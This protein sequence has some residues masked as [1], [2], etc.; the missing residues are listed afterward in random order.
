MTFD[1]QTAMHLQGGAD[2]HAAFGLRNEALDPRSS[3]V[4]LSG[5]AIEPS[6]GVFA[7]GTIPS[8]PHASSSSDGVTSTFYAHSTAPRINTDVL[9]CEALRKQ[10]PSLSLTVSLTYNCPLMTYA[11]AGFATAVPLTDDSSPLGN[12]L[13]WRLWAPPARRTGGAQ[14]RLADLVQYGKYLYKYRQSPGMKENEFIIY[15]VSGRDGT[16]PFG[17]Q[18]N[19]YI[20]SSASEKP[21]VDAL[22]KASA[23]WM[24]ELHH[25]VLVFDNGFWQKS[26]ELWESVQKSSWDDVILDPQMKRD[27]IG[28]VDSFFASRD[29]YGRLGVPWKRGIIYYGPPGNGKTIS[30]KAMM[31]MLQQRSTSKSKSKEASEGDDQPQKEEKEEDEKE[32][33]EEIPT[34]YVKT[35]A[36]FL[37][38]EYSVRSI[39]ARARAEAPCYLVFEDL[40]SVV[41][42]RVRSYFLNEVDGLKANDGIFMVGSTNHLDR[43]DPGIAKRPSRF[44]RKYFFPNPDAKER[45]AYCR[46]WQAKLERAGRGGGG[47]SGDGGDDGKGKKGKGAVEFPDTMVPAIAGITGGFSFAYIQEAFV[48]SLLAIARDGGGDDNDDDDDDD[49]EE[50]EK[51]DEEEEGDEVL[52]E[53]EDDDNDDG[54]GGGGGGGKKPGKDHPELDKYKLWVEIK[55]QVETLREGLEDAGAEDGKADLPSVIGRLGL[56]S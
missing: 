7:P 18:N 29:T 2:A 55:K 28:D 56:G 27:I 6:N 51:G 5:A 24:L 50:H 11:A 53:A 13:K 49:E 36:S 22:L 54:G 31:H 33:S 8:D 40:D 41:S 4:N 10:Y 9:I 3:A 48:A 42:D 15:V 52:V 34:L 19:T 39:F 47:D 26:R 44:D 1:A 23:S 30:I 35:L 45:E 14:G 38:P 12:S 37:G 25:E 17:Q 16:S 32:Q 43:L 20:L 21:A 46:Y